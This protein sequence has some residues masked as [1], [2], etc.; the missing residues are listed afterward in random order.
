MAPDEFLREAQFA[1]ELS[2]RIE[3]KCF[4]ERRFLARSALKGRPGPRF[5]LW[6]VASAAG[7]LGN[8]LAEK[9]LLDIEDLYRSVFE[10]ILGERVSDEEIVKTGWPGITDYRAPLRR[11]ADLR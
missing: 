9:P 1:V 2:R 3:N 5:N 8:F 7:G 6:S 10:G 4:D 11:R